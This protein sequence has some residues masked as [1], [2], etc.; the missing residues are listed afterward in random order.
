[1]TLVEE[2]ASRSLK[3]FRVQ[4]GA[5][6]FKQPIEFGP[7]S[8]MFSIMFCCRSDRLRTRPSTAYCHMIVVVMGGHYYVL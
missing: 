2:G 3:G 6:E 7:N 4:E 5:V 8:V 1:M